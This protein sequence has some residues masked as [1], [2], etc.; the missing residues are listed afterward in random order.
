MED[1]QLIDGGGSVNADELDILNMQFNI[2]Y[3]MRTEVITAKISC[4]VST[5]SYH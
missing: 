5:Q 2:I 1:K 4:P 3:I